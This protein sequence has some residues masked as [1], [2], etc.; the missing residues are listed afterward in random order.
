MTEPAGE[1]GSSRLP[2]LLNLEKLFARSDYRPA[3]GLSPLH[4]SE[5]F[6]NGRW[7]EILA[8]RQRLLASTPEDFVCECASE[9]DRRIVGSFARRW[10]PDLEVGSFVK[11]GREWEPDFIVVDRHPPHSVLGGCV[12]F[13]SGW[14]LPEKLAQPVGFV[15][16]RVPVLNKLLGSRIGQFLV[17]LEVDKFY[18]RT[19]WGLTSSNQLNQHPKQQ[20][21]LIQPYRSDPFLRIEW[22]AFGALSAGL[23]LFGIRIFHIPFEQVRQNPEATA[24]LARNLETMSPEMLQYKRLDGC[25]DQLVSLLKGGVT[26]AIMQYPE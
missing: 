24:L 6:N 13:P 12:C 21:P 10:N 9:P 22:Q 11:L 15:H 20:I 18:Q 25:R 1:L 14:S 23:I 5:Y 26:A 17:R 16:A 4:V 7:P 8:E 2:P 3:M 19:N